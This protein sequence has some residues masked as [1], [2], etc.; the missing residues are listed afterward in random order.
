MIHGL[1]GGALWGLDTVILGVVLSMGIFSDTPQ[2]AFL[3]PFVSTFLHDLASSVWM[4]GYMGIKKQCRATVQVFRT[5]SG[6]FIVLGAVLGGPVGM[7]AYVTAIQLIG[8]SYTAVISAMYPALGTL[9]A[10]LFLKERLKSVQIF[11]MALSI[12]GVVAMG[13]T[14]GA[15]V[16]TNIPLG[17]TCAVLGCV[18]WALEAVVCAYGMRN[19]SVTNENALQIRQ[20][21]SALVYAVVILNFVRGWDLVGKAVSE[22]S[23]GLICLS[24][25]FG[26]ASYLCYYKAISKLGSSKA[27]ALNITYS[28]WAIIYTLLIL[29]VMPDVKS[30]VC[31]LIIMIG[32]V[33]AAAEW[34]RQGK[35][36]RK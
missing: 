31:A 13:Y 10:F 26:T 7:S 5:G 27:M 11:G 22:R 19:P 8:P 18:G 30:V 35:E 9:F 36:E 34:K 6:R 24:A 23:L 33:I 21:V 12:G 20:T 32:S 4:L 1:A 16:G 28:A 3:A 25:L 17:I 15:E 2:A 14:P 29:G